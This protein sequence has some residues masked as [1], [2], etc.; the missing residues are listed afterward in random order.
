MNKIIHI[1]DDLFNQQLLEYNG[2][3]LLEFSADWCGPCQKQ[4]IILEQIAKKYSNNIKI[5]K[6]DIDESPKLT[7]KFNIKSVPTIFIFKDG[8]KVDSITGLSTLEDL[9][10]YF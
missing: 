8:V 5:I 1:N 10:P 4:L 3:I 2:T 7:S 9:I 6:V